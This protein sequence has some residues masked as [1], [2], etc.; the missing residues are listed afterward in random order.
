[1]KERLFL[2]GITLN[3]AYIAPRY[4]ESPPT[5]ETDFADSHLS[6]GNGTIVSA[7][8]ATHAVAVELFVQRRCSFADVPF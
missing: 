3:A 8:V 4:V 5:I 2:N 1:M 7:G 6:V